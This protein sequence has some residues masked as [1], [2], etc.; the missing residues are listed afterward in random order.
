MYCERFRPIEYENNA[1]FHTNGEKR[2]LDEV[3]PHIEIAFDVGA[4]EGEWT[5]LLLSLAPN[6]SNIYTF[7]PSKA[8]FSRLIARRFPPCVACQP[9]ALSSRIGTGRL[10][11]F[12]QNSGLNSL[13]N[14]E[15]LQDGWGIEHSDVAE[16]VTLQ[17]IDRFCAEH[18][19]PKVDFI[20]IDTEGHEVD[21]LIGA[22]ES[23][24]RGLIKI[25]QFEYG[26][27]YIDSRKLLKDVFEFIAPFD[28]TMFLIAP[29]VLSVYFRYDQ[30]L[31]NFQYKNFVMFHNK[32]IESI[33]SAREAVQ[34]AQHSFAPH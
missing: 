26:G 32:M 24:S 5:A 17:T 31:E 30:R 2:I 34:R 23:L 14:R 8:N 11:T 4:H 20:K 21:V 16:Q 18:S 29:E 1:D 28:Y 3:S 25:I 13:H 19:I 10:Y 12:D 6:I 15:G 33:P 22:R 7:E 9:I 27:T